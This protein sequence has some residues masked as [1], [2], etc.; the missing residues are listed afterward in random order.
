MHGVAAEAGEAMPSST[1][2]RL[3]T[4]SAALPLPAT[5]DAQRWTAVRRMR[6]VTLA[7][8]LI[9]LLTVSVRGER[10]TTD[11][12]D[13]LVSGDGRYVVLQGTWRRTSQRP[14]VEVPYVNSVRIE[15]DRLNSRRDKEVWQYIVGVAA[16]LE[17]LAVASCGLMAGSRAA[18]RTTR[19]T[20]LSDRPS[21]RLRGRGS[22]PQPL[23]T[24]PAPS[25][26]SGTRLLIRERYPA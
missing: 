18:S 3:P 19:T 5:P 7:A 10:I 14:T 21:A 15:C 23:S 17:D 26:D 11:Q 4:A 24:R 1:V 12:K 9:L 22:S 20:S 16:H 2:T 13:F 6:I 25:T 8:A